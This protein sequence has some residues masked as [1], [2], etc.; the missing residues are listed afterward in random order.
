MCITHIL[1]VYACV[2]VLCVRVCMCLHMQAMCVT[3][4]V[5][6]VSDQ[7]EKKLEVIHELEQHI[8]QVRAQRLLKEEQKLSSKPNDAGS[9]L[10]GMY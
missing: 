7:Y 1:C 3:V 10:R 9:L 2:C 5:A 8:Q 4:C 6:Q